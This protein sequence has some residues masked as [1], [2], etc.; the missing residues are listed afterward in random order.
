MRHAG[1]QATDWA[2]VRAAK[3]PRGRHQASRLDVPGAPPE[4]QRRRGVSSLGSAI[5]GTVSPDGGRGCRVRGGFPWL[6]RRWNSWARSRCAQGGRIHSQ[7]ERGVGHRRPR[8]G[9]HPCRLRRR[10]RARPSRRGVNTDGWFI[11]AA[12]REI[13]E[14]G[15]PHE[16]VWSWEP[17]LSVVVQQWAHDA[18]MQAWNGVLGFQG[19]GAACA[20]E[21]AALVACLWLL[22]PSFRSG[23]G[24]ERPC[25]RILPCSPACSPRC[26]TSTS[27]PR[28]GR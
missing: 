3:G 27:G 20:I 9:R 11:L 6:L 13:L 23:W 19:V 22:L 15:I 2:V 14:N 8:R 24:A 18:W 25:A 17:G 4:A 21:A 1:P 28:C 26:P 16:N 7:A 12:G 10:A 5:I